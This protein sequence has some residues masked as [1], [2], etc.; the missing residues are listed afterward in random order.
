MVMQLICFTRVNTVL[1][2]VGFTL[3]AMLAIAGL[4]LQIVKRSTDTVSSRVNWLTPITVTLPWKY[5]ATR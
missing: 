4:I 5:L 2:S 1:T 3:P